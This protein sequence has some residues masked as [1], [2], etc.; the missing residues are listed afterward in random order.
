MPHGHVSFLFLLLWGIMNI[1]ASNLFCII[2]TFDMFFLLFYYILVFYQNVRVVFNKFCYAED[3]SIHINTIQKAQ[4]T[5]HI[6]T[7][8]Y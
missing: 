5:V 7:F 3:L 8:T 4:H 2:L 1:A 6:Y